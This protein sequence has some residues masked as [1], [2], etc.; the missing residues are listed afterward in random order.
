MP[1]T[2]GPEERT[3]HSGERGSG[4]GVRPYREL[5]VPGAPVFEIR[6]VQERI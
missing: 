1:S 3:T 4:R 5:S 6:Q 2:R